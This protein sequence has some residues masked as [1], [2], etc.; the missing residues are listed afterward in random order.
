[1]QNVHTE[2][3]STVV[4][5]LFGGDE[6]AVR[7]IFS[8]SELRVWFSW[9]QGAWSLEVGLPGP[10]ELGSWRRQQGWLQCAPL[11]G[12]CQ[13]AQPNTYGLRPLPASRTAV[14][15]LPAMQVKMGWVKQWIHRCE[16]CAKTM[17]WQP[18]VSCG[19][20]GPSLPGLLFASLGCLW[21][22][23]PQPPNLPA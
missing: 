11:L 18:S 17:L 8:T 14:Q 20:E 4:E 1:M 9:A 6:E 3:V 22:I 15:A 16:P 12:T 23:P 19:Q 21:I 5:A 2:M 7:A 10:Q 13:P